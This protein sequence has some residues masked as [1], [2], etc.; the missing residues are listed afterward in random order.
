MGFP[1]ERL[2][3]WSTGELLALTSRLAVRAWEDF[4]GRTMGVTM[5][6]YR[7]LTTLEEEPTSQVAL[8]GRCR[9][10]PQ[11]LGRT[12]DRLERDGLV[13]RERHG[14]DRRVTSV[15]RTPA[16]DRVVAEVAAV[17]AEGDL[18]LFDRLPDLA[19][20]RA[21]LV[22]VIGLLSASSRAHRRER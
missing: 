15:V 8:A 10:G 2:E 22:Q 14:G 9:V 5:A 21:D 16:G 12:L 18:K 19:R 4:L 3:G 1:D 17:R 20:F 13:R 7:V 11:S 6:G